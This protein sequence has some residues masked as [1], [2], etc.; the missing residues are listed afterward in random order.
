MRACENLERGGE[1]AIEQKDGMVFVSH[2]TPDKTTITESMPALGVSYPDTDKYFVGRT[3]IYFAISAKNL[4]KLVC[5]A[6]S[7]GGEIPHIIFHIAAEDSDLN[8]IRFNIHDNSI[9]GIVMPVRILEK[10]T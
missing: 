1:I 8:P 3:E 6:R 2:T 9:I 4:E 5:L 10:N 7:A